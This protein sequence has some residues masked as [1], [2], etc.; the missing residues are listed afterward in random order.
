MTITEPT[1]KEIA[2]RKVALRNTQF[3]QEWLIPELELP[4]DTDVVAWISK[5]KY[6]T[7]KELLITE[8]TAVEITTAIKNKR[9]TAVDVTTAFC[10][11]ALIAHQLVNCLTEVF[12]DEGI[13][14]A[15]ALDAYYEETGKLKGSLHGLPVS[16]KDNLNI[17]GHGSTIGL[18]NF[19][20]NPEKHETDAVLVT[21]LRDAGAVFYVKTNTPVAMMMPETNNHIWGN[22]VNPM[23]RNLSAGGS[24]GG[25]AALI[26]LKGSP[27]GIGSDIGG[28]IRIP[29]SFQNL[30]GLRPTFGRFPTFG[31]RSGLAGFESI[32]SVN[33]PI[34]NAIED[35]ELYSKAV[36]DL[37]PENYDPKVIPMP[38]S[39]VEVGEVLNIAVVI[40]DGG[41]RPSPPIRRGMAIAIE[42]LTNAGHNIIEWDTSNHQEIAALGGQ[43]YV[44]DGGK[45]VLKET[46]A[47][48]EELFPYMK[49]YGECKDMP[50]SE[51]W[52]LQYQ[53]SSLMK[54]ILDR[55]L[56]TADRTINGKPIDAIIMPVSPFAGSPNHKF[57]HYVGYTSIFNI[58]DW[59]ACTFPVTRA[60]KDIDIRDTDCS[61]YC[62]TDTKVWEEYDPEET[63]GGAVALQLVGRNYEE[64]KVVAMTK[65]VAQLIN[66]VE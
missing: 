2:A 41:V 36:M 6:L 25:E 46:T 35:M 51:L 21:L 20:F 30:Y 61:H 63:H 19:C 14:Q 7:S 50:T 5:C 57:H 58:M 28:S 42:K 24:S 12:F 1:Y 29:S 53:K 65:K 13:A 8:S 59:T 52:D 48:G 16:L 40:D 45:H 27:L 56:N 34:C 3:K 17:A 10:H 62:F 4:E 60:D 26:K 39:P 64:E 47:V 54:I 23:N 9:W 49:H 66:Y 11:R 32:N 22:T 43:L 18:V 55:W 15:A 31:A 33:G 37:H 44:S 38:W